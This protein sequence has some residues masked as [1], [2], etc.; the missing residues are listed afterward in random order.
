MQTKQLKL[1]ITLSVL[2]VLT[3]CAS[4]PSGP[5]DSGA[6][7]RVTP[8]TTSAGATPPRI[9]R[10][11]DRYDFSAVKAATL[12]LKAFDSDMNQIRQGSGFYTGSGLVVTNAH[13]VKGAAFVE[14]YNDHADRVGNAPYALYINQDLDLAILPAPDLPVPALSGHTGQVTAG[15]P[16]W[17]VGS[18]MGFA[19]TL[20]RGIVSAIRTL[21]DQRYLQIS[22]PVSPGSSGGP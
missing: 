7:V 21:G 19:D 6:S 11:S 12:T 13:V 2:L 20:S 4:S 17:V 16:V 10:Q 5:I 8:A 15:T 18:P 14:M 9:E 3:A 22:A 1:W